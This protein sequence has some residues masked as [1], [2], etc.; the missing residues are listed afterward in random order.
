MVFFS[1]W[2]KNVSGK[3]RYKGCN[4][5]IGIVTWPSYA[6][7]TPISELEC[8][9]KADGRRDGYTTGVCGDEYTYMCSQNMDASSSNDLPA[10]HRFG[11][12]TTAM[13]FIFLLW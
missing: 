13:V 1:S 11:T 12:I 6:L 10:I 9:L 2:I 8:A 3:R 4:K 7:L 5:S